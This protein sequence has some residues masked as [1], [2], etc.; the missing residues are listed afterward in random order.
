MS[1]WPEGKSAAVSLS[2]DDGRLSQID[3]GMAILDGAGI[4]ATFYVLPSAVEERLEGWRAAVAR[5]HE[6]GNHTLSHPC[7]GNFL[8]SRKN[9]LE[10]LTLARLAEDIDAAQDGLFRLLEVA[11]QTF[12][13]P[14]GQTFVGRG[15]DV[16]S[17]VPLVAERFLAGRVYPSEGY[18]APDAC[19]LAQVYGYP[20][21]NT[22]L[23]DLLAMIEKAR[24]EEGWLVLVGHETR[25]EGA[26][27]VHLDVLEELC[28]Y[29]AHPDN[30][31]HCD[32]VAKIASEIAAGKTQA[33][34]S[35]PK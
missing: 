11:P 23:D 16:A 10:D 14:C 33:W 8:F 25:D 28:A 19:D 7:S 34:D 22:R 24:A 9:A 35:G 3:L 30:G 13:Y 6:I 12:A 2:F 1:R 15:R 26:Q 17:Y 5:G 29:L 20:M 18:N 4:R 27:T 31:I 21:D 32:T